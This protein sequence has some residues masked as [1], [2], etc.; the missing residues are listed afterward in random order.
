VRSIDPE[1]RRIHIREAVAEVNYKQVL[2]GVKSH[3]RRMVA[4]PDFL[5]S[6]VAAACAG[7]AP[8]DRLWNAE[9]GTFLR[10]GHA[11][12]GWFAGAVKRC[13]KVDP[14][15]RRV[16]PHD[17]RHT[18]ASLAISAGANGKVVQRMLGHKSA[19]VTL[20]TYAALFPDDLDNLTEALS[21]QRS[22]QLQAGTPE[23]A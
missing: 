16:T 3:E 8:E 13:E 10:A 5:D 7:K 20:D 22:A 21:R 11:H 23:G 14:T 1:R 2:G 6:E 17:L 18:A 15:F 9:D 19:K 4:Y 12:Q